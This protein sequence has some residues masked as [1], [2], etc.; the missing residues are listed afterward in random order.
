M[1]DRR[2]QDFRIEAAERKLRLDEQFRR[3]M[4]GEAT[5]LLSLEIYGVKPADAKQELRDRQLEKLR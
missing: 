4:I 5:Y 3:G 2:Q 1:L